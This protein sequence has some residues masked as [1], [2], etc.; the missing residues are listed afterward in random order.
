MEK[1]NL[2]VAF[3]PQKGGA[4]KTKWSMPHVT[5]PSSNHVVQLDPMP[6]GSVEDF[7]FRLFFSVLLITF[8]FF[9]M[10]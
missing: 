4:G 6:S 10:P 3:S 7:C 9:Y 1:K 8:D 5:T 2:Y